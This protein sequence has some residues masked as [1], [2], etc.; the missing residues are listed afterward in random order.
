M[1]LASCYLISFPQNHVEYCFRI[2][3]KLQTDNVHS[4]WG[5]SGVNSFAHLKHVK[6]LP[7]PDTLF[8]IAILG[9]PFDTAVSYRPG[10][11]VL[12]LHSSDSHVTIFPPLFPFS[13]T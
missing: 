13:E 7:K 8:D 11:S 9:A 12:F 4:Q 2:S 1:L 6:C 5:F 3:S 10:I